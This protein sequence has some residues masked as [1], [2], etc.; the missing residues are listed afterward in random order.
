MWVGIFFVMTAVVVKASRLRKIPL[1]RD[2]RP[3]S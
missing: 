1:K 2:Q 3:N